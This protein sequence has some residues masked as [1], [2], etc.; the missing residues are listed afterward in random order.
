MNSEQKKNALK[1]S[2]ELTIEEIENV[3]LLVSKVKRFVDLLAILPDAEREFRADKDAFLKKYNIED[4]NKEELSF[5]FLQEYE[6]EREKLKSLSR[7]EYL[8]KVPEYLFRYNQFI[9]NKLAFRNYLCGDGLAPDNAKLKK[10]RKRMINR[11]NGDLGGGNRAFVHA[12]VC[13]EMAVGCSVGCEFCGLNAGQLRAVYRHT[14][15]NAKLFKEVLTACKEIIGKACAAGMLYF[16]SEPLDNP[17]YE[18]FENDFYEIFKMI[19]QITTATANRHVDKLKRLIRNTEVKQGFLHRFTI[20]SEE[21]ANTIFEQFTPRELLK[22]ELLP[23]FEEAPTFGGFVKSGKNTETAVKT[24]VTYDELIN[25]KGKIKYDT[26]SI[27]C[28]DGFCINMVEKK[29]TLFTP[30]KSSEKYPKGISELEPVYFENGVDFKKKLEYLIDTY[31]RTEIPKD[32]Q[33]KLYDYFDILDTKE[34]GKILFSE[35]GGQILQLD[36]F[37][38][39]YFMPILELLQD[40]KKTYAEIIDDICTRYNTAPENVIYLLNQLWNM[41]YIVDSVFF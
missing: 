6:K 32:E 28:I 34:Y 19:P 2:S 4:L 29:I 5:C 15:E 30:C 31:I 35:H 23:Q 16:A 8:D 24:S 14:E 27:V 10:W 13:F 12:P 1:L 17:D 18:E 11:C 25:A 38:H 7:D 22:V 40:G 20:L 36:K 21:M 39:D 9:A 41:G 26:G 3:N 37:P 33:L